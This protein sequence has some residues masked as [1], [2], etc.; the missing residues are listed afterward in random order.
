MSPSSGRSE[1]GIGRTCCSPFT[2]AIRARSLTPA[3]P[4]KRRGRRV[5]HSQPRRRATSRSR[6]T[7]PYVG[8]KGAGSCTH[9]FTRVHA[10]N[11]ISQN[12]P[13]STCRWFTFLSLSHSS[14]LGTHSKSMHWTPAPIDYVSQPRTKQ[15]PSALIH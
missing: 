14:A 4:I 8:E 7:C 1:A 3:G 2:S 5:I 12:M 10:R 15:R 6:L 9:F 13:F 11:V